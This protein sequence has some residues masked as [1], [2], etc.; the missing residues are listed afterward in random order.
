MSSALEV[1]QS[2]LFVGHKLK[3]AE[4]ATTRRCKENKTQANIFYPL[5]CP[6]APIYIWYMHPGLRVYPTP[7]TEEP[8]NV[9][10]MNRNAVKHISIEA[11]SR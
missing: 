1:I 4:V 7:K 6:N 2:R 11:G 9:Y 10:N 5:T 3:D 8:K